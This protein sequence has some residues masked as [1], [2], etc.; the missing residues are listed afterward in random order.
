[1]DEG[2]ADED[3]YLIVLRWDAQ[4]GGVDGGAD[5][6][7]PLY[8]SNSGISSG[9]ASTS[10]PT[11]YRFSSRCLFTAHSVTTSFVELGGFQTY[12]YTQRVLLYQWCPL[13]LCTWMGAKN[14]GA[15]FYRNALAR[16]S[17]QQSADLYNDLGAALASQRGRQ[18][19]AAAAYVQAIQIAPV[20]S[21]AYNNLAALL[22]TASPP[23][24]SKALS[25][26]LIAHSLQ[27]EQYERYP[28]MHLN[29][30]SVLVDAARYDEAIW[31]YGRGLRYEPQAEDTLGRLVHLSQ[32]VCDWRAVDR[33]WPHVRHLLTKLRRR[34]QQQAQRPAISPM[35][36]LTLPLSASELLTLAQ[37]HSA[38]IEAEAATAHSLL[39][40]PPEAPSAGLLPPITSAMRAADRPETAASAAA[41]AA[42]GAAAGSSHVRHGTLHIGLLSF[43]FKRH[44]VAI[45]LARALAAVRRH[46]PGV[47][48][49]LFALNAMAPSL[50]VADTSPALD[51]EGDAT[52]SS[53][54]S[55]ADETVWAAR[56]RAAVHATVP[57]HNVSDTK[58]AAQIRAYGV[59]VLLDLNGLYS[60][61]ARPGILARRP[62]PVQATHLGY[63][64]ST[65]ARFVDLVLADQIAL[66]PTPEHAALHTEKMLL[67]PPSHLP[68]GH[69]ELY[70]HLLRPS[71]D[72]RTR[73]RREADT[74]SSA[75]AAATGRAARH[76]ACTSHERARYGLPPRSGAVSSTRSGAR[77]GEVLGYFGQHLKI[78]ESTFGQ[79][80]SML[81]R[82]PRSVL[83]MLRWPSSTTRLQQQAAA[84][85]VR[86][87]RLVFTERLAQGEHL[88]A[89]ALADLAL[90]SPLY[91]SGATGVDV[92]WSG[93][94]ILALAGGMRTPAATGANAGA[95][96][97]S[98]RASTNIFQRN[99][100]S[101]VAA[102]AQ[103]YLQAHTRSGYEELGLG[104]VQRPST[105]AAAQARARS[106]RASA[107]LFDTRRW[108]LAFTAGLHM[109]W[110]VR[111]SS[112]VRAA[113]HLVVARPFTTGS[114]SS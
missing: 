45:L 101:L 109:A 64:A 48:L 50:A 66:P 83:W 33:L 81:Q 71:A 14:A 16:S 8:R 47:T 34:G 102:A 93:V 77:H 95:H 5:A 107:P 61:G 27:P 80:L 105:R 2:R 51:A 100:I 56:L 37:A 69:A 90:D 88:C 13:S 72:P 28:Q 9:D 57:L 23:Q 3:F 111:Q 52:A 41:A 104:L 112:G 30:A 1:M 4:H 75:G 103:P 39:G 10:K 43:D 38:A 79:W 78:D 63:G 12:R 44:P 60:R 97:A 59:H 106:S 67:M 84:V 53:L 85:G 108:A 32:R 110:E 96:A 36:A 11:I 87:D 76:D 98:H 20:H 22:L 82:Q 62:A 91:S 55:E 35:H 58:A 49:T 99:A 15:D 29:L 86:V 70:P 46:C 21:V 7:S 26:Y 54:A 42:V 65:G 31:H 18:R 94:P 73:G 92:L 114:S 68:A 17:S 25:M 6:Q 74:M 113:M 19:E 89:F 24:R 40:A